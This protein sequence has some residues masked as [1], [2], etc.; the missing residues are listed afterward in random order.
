MWFIAK[1]ADSF[2]GKE[3]HGLNIGLSYGTN[4]DAVDLFLEEMQ[5]AKSQSHKG[6]IVISLARV[7]DHRAV[8]KLVE[9]AMDSKEQD[10]TRAL[11]TAGL[12]L[13]GDLEWIPSLAR[14]SKHVNYRASTDV[15][16]E[17][18]SIL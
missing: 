6:Q 15:V 4:Q 13:V 9:L 1:R 8:D 12:G 7:G 10:L 2:L 11:A 16:D 14:L 3:G 18:L 5:D 17:V